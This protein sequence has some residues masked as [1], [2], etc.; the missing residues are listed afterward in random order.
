VSST[1]DGRDPRRGEKWGWAGGFL[2]SSLWIPVMGILLLYWGDVFA[3]V[4]AFALYAAALVLLYVLLPWRNP[5]RP[6]GL[7]LAGTLA[8]IFAAIG[9]SIY[10]FFIREDALT[11]GVQPFS[12][13]WVTV[14]LPIFFRFGRRT[15]DDGHGRR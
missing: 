12:F 13:L 1:R 6:M 15:W 7:L 14:F 3:G 2:G 5:R 9:L 8:P 4:V 11:E 10:Y